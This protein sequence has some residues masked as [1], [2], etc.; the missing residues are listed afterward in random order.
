RQRTATKMPAGCSLAGEREPPVA[1]AAVRLH[2]DERQLLDAIG[3]LSRAPRL[4][5][6]LFRCRRGN[7]QIFRV[8]HGV[9][10]SLCS[11]YKPIDAHGNHALLT[12]LTRTVNT[13]SI[14]KFHDSYDAAQITHVKFF[15]Q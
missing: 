11:F 6:A 14:S 9:S 2:G 3:R 13:A 5:I 10:G 1:N 4:G 8:R 7:A 12:A 15:L